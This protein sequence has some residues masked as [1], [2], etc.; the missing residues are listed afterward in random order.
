MCTTLTSRRLNFKLILIFTQFLIIL[1]EF[2]ALNTVLFLRNN[3]PQ[4]TIF[5]GV[6]F[7]N[8]FKG[9]SC[10]I[11]SL[12]SEEHFT[13]VRLVSSLRFKGSRI[14]IPKCPKR[15]EGV[16]GLDRP[17]SLKAFL[18]C[19][20]KNAIDVEIKKQIT[21]QDFSTFVLY[22]KALT[23][24]YSKVTKVP[25]ERA[26]GSRTVDLRLVYTTVATAPAK[27]G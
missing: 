8:S 17:L 3:R 23:P 22:F 21:I 24:L 19:I 9:W 20:N 4:K 7:K 1:T 10:R 6:F 15:S 14:Q 16:G 11:Y 25:R 2:Y 12:L 13:R 18:Y 5:V 26:V 27:N